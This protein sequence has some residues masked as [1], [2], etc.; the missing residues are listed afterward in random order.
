[1]EIM[2]RKT[3]LL[4]FDMKERGAVDFKTQSIFNNQLSFKRIIR[5]LLIAKLI[6]IV[7]E[8]KEKYKL[9]VIGGAFIDRIR[10]YTS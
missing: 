2:S 4:L 7:W 10:T 8:G 6:Y 5:R 1:M 9:T 3:Q